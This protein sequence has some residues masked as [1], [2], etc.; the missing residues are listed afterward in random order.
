MRPIALH[1]VEGLIFVS[2][3]DRPLGLHDVDEMLRSTIGPLGWADAKVV[4]QERYD[5]AANWKLAL[6]NQ[7]E[8]YHCATSHPEYVR[9]HSQG[10]ADID[11][12]RA[13]MLERAAA[14]GIAHP[15]P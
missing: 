6:E 10:R 14:Q 12:A 9:V 4:H 7:V 3:A 2:L 13:R 11:A 1:V 15:L 8:C 5:I